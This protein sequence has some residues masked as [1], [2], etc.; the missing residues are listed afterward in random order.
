[1]SKGLL[2][3]QNVWFWLVD[4][5]VLPAQALYLCQPS[6]STMESAQFRTWV[7]PSALHSSSHSS[8]RVPRASK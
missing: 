7:M 8:L 4:F 2:E 5:V 1:V 3:E 6:H